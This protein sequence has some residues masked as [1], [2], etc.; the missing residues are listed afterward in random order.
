M[1]MI[2]AIV[3]SLIEMASI[4]LLLRAVLSW[5]YTPYQ[6]GGFGS[7]LYTAVCQITEPI[8]LPFRMLFDRLGIGRNFPIDLSFAATV[9]ALQIIASVL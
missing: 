8:L 2:R 1:E 5:F 3:L 7:R 9:I 4:L 6:S